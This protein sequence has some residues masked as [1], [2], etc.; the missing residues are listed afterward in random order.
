MSNFF[1]IPTPEKV[2]QTVANL[3]RSRLAL[4]KATLELDEVTSRLEQETRQKWIARLQDAESE[5]QP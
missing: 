1:E 4:E 3:R 2:K 5:T